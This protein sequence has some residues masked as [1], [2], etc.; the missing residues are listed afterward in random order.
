M[1]EGDKGL[2]NKQPE[3]SGFGLRK[4]QRESATA[5]AIPN[6]GRCTWLH[7]VLLKGVVDVAQHEVVVFGVTNMKGLFL[8]T[9]L[10][11]KLF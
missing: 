7:L 9:K 2:K 5:S 10:I 6:H 11:A 4:C 3:P 1:A 8:A